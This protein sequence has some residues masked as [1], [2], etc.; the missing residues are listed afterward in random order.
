VGAGAPAKSASNWVM[1]EVLRVLSE[2][3]GAVDAFPVSAIDLAG[4]IGLVE[5][6]TINAPSAKKIF[7]KLLSEGGSP[8]E[9]VSTLGLE[10]VSN[11]SELDDMVQ[12]AMDANPQSVED[13]RNGKKAAAQFLMGQVMRLSRGKANPPMVLKLLEE[14]LGS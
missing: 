9:W 11:S 10:Q 5:S 1:T 13:Y 3:D 8:Q 12:Q 4:L 6:K 14:R 2:G 7:E